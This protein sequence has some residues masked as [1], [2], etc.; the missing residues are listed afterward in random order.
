MNQIR[1]YLNTLL[2]LSLQAACLPAAASVAGS[3]DRDSTA[4]FSISLALQPSLEIRTASDITINIQDRTVDTTYRQPFCVRGT[5]DAKY[6]LTAYGETA[7]GGRF[8]LQGAD[9][10]LLPFTLEYLGNLAES[11]PD[12]LEPDTPSQVYS[13]LPFGQDCGDKTWFVVTFESDDLRDVGSGLYSG[14]VTFLVSPV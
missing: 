13:I 10:Q 1:R 9:G 11:R 6:T 8:A 3:L 14:S 12:E 5:A 7:G 4:R 2:L